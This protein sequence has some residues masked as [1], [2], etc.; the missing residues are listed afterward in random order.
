MKITSYQEYIYEVT[1]C[2]ALDMGLD[3]EEAASAALSEVVYYH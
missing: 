3:L 2:Y 1:F